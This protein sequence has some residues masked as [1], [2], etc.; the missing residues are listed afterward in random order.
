MG[1]HIKPKLTSWI[2]YNLQLERSNALGSKQVQ[3]SQLS[4]PMNVNPIALTCDVKRKGGIQSSS[5][6]SCNITFAFTFK[7]GINRTLS[8]NLSNYL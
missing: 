6:K 7:I 1:H 5:W 3:L 2:I 8:K 4:T